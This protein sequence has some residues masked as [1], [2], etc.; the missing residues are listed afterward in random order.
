MQRKN[1]PTSKCHKSKSHYFIIENQ[2]T[3]NGSKH[4]LEISQVFDCFKY[5][6]HHACSA[7]A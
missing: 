5:W 3:F 2:A 6:M 7:A 1:T 4:Q